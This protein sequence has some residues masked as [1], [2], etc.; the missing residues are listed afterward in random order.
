[1]KRAP[2]RKMAMGLLFLV[3]VS[4]IAW[5]TPVGAGIRRRWSTV[6]RM[7]KRP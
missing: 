5:R 6:V 4:V 7:E 1:M 3:A 2:V